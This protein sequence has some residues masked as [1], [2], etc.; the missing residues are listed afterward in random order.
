[1]NHRIRYFCSTIAIPLL[2]TLP[3]ICN[4]GE[5]RISVGDNHMLLVKDDGSLWAWGRN[6]FGA[7]GLDKDIQNAPARIP[8]ANGFIDVVAR[9]SF[10]LALKADG[11]VWAWGDN[12][13]GRIGPFNDRASKPVQ[14]KGLS[15]IVAINA[16]WRFSAYAVGENG[17]V[18]SWGDN[19]YGELGT[20]TDDADNHPIPAFIPGLNNVTNVSSADV[21][22]LAL[23]ANRIVKAW[24]SNANGDLGVSSQNSVVPPLIVT[25]LTD[26][27]ELADVA[28]NTSNGHFA[29]KA[30]GEV[31]SWGD[32]NGGVVNCGQE[33]DFDLY[34]APVK[35]GGIPAI[36]KMSGGGQHI[37]FLTE[38]DTIVGCG[39]NSWGQ[40]GDNSTQDTDRDHVGPVR[41][42][43]L[44]NIAWVTAGSSASAAIGKDGSV[45]TWGKADEGLAGTG[46]DYESNAKNVSP[47]KLGF[48]AGNSS[49]FPAVFAGTQSS[50]LFQT[51]IDIGFAAAAA[52]IGQNGRV[53]IAALLP[54]GTLFLLDKTGAFK[55]YTAESLIYTY[56]GPIPRHLPVSFGNG[57]F[58]YAQGV[59]LL[60]GYGMGNGDAAGNELLNSGRYASVLTLQ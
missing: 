28:I 37:L 24:G 12:S 50:S 44:T 49:D 17:Q 48:N 43:S 31:W 16:N 55:P 35:I 46:I 13:G 59:S 4:A 11:T 53:Y 20:G 38:S 45:W 33:R 1:M 18:W 19:G 21:T 25:G 23:D 8:D 34:K 27:K 26:V 42:G 40:L 10:S 52:H 15:R 2:V 9:D 36:Q 57:D 56:E 7:L 58:S 39:I 3:A 47:V 41:A 5:P 6:T 30:N 51:D 22:A 29:L 54:D 60:I 14:V 32:S